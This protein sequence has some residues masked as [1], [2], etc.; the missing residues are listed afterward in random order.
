M[1][2]ARIDANYLTHP[3]IRAL[4]QDGK[5]LHL[6]SVLYCAGHDIGDG[7]IPASSLDVV[8]SHAALGRH[9]GQVFSTLVVGRLWVPAE[10]GGY[11]LHNYDRR[12]GAHSRA[13]QDRLRKRRSRDESRG[14]EA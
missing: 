9:Q 3:K 13:A 12:N 6:A 10:G 5:L 14:E 8:A 11:V 4:S 2:W 1:D 7:Y